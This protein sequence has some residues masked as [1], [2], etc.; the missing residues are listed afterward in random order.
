MRTNRQCSDGNGSLAHC[1]GCD[2]NADPVYALA[3]SVAIS[4][5]GESI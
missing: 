4:I 2:I 1:L 3:I 5:K